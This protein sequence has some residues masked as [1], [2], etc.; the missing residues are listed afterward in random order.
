MPDLTRGGFYGVHSGVVRT[1]YA[2]PGTGPHAGPQGPRMAW[3][4]PM[5]LVFKTGQ[6]W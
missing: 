5:G 2:S 4:S 6:V 3:L 1:V